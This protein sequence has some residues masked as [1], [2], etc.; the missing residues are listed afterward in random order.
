MF[1]AYVDI[2]RLQFQEAPKALC[3]RRTYFPSLY[4]L[5]A[6]STRK[7]SLGIETVRR[8]GPFVK[9]LGRYGR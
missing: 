2:I 8:N 9:R 7:P 3:D 4:I 6:R 5:A 1:E